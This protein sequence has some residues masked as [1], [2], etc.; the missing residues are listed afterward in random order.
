MVRAYLSSSFQQSWTVFFIPLMDE[1]GVCTH[2]RTIWETHRI[3][4]YYTCANIGP[5]GNANKPSLIIRHPTSAL[6]F[7]LLVSQ[8]HRSIYVMFR[9]LLCF[10]C[11]P[12]ELLLLETLRLALYSSEEASSA[13]AMSAPRAG[14][15]QV[16]G[17]NS[18]YTIKCRQ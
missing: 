17:T 18:N 10:S 8:V 11:F 14:A 1:V 4:R 2:R 13:S 5:V 3:V 6:A 12:S 7:S 15:V 9:F 16:A